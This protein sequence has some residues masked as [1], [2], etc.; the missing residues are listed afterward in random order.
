MD[1]RD[2]NFRFDGNIVRAWR[3]LGDMAAGLSFLH[4]NN[5]VHAN[6]KLLNIL[7]SPVRGAVLVDFS[8]SFREG[9][10]LRSCGAPWYL[11][12]EFVTSGDSRGKPSD[13]WALGVVM[14]WVLDRIPVS[15]LK[16]FILPFGMSESHRLP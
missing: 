3:I 11:P 1:Y 10:R 14:M 4:A 2:S 9:A 7:F 12:P 6:I 5:I 8:I 15:P 16:S 13:M